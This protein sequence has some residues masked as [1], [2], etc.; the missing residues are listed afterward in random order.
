MVGAKQLYKCLACGKQFLGGQRLDRSQVWK[1]YIHGKQ[2]YEQLASKYGKSERTIRRLLAPVVVIPPPK[3]PR[4]IVLL[5]DTTYW[6]RNFG[7]MLFKDAWTGENLHKIYVQ[8]E[9]VA[10]YRQG[11]LALEEMG[12]D[13]AA[14]VCDGKRG[15][16]GGF[17]SAP[18]Q[19][20]QFHQVAIITRYITKK[21]KTQAAKELRNIV[22]LLS[23]TDKES[24]TGMLRDWSENWRGFLDER[25]K[26]P[27]SGKTR[28]VHRRLR[29]AYRSLS[30]NL[31]WLFTWYDLMELRIPNTTNAIDGEFAHLKNKLRNHNGLSTKMKIKF[32][33]EF[34]KA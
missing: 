24:F 16:L 15:L 30:S 3:S 11:V 1:E 10:L 12:F 7:V 9:S 17:G 28:F 6:G 25:A 8:S 29:S 5:M 20:C 14:I 2:T 13:I 21:P 34:L 26:D 4:K 32:I 22:L 18:T 31:P 33:D 19:M 27:E 23:R